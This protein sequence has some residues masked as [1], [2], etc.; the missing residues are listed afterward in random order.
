MN[1]ERKM[2]NAEKNI[3]LEDE[4]KHRPEVLDIPPLN[5][6]ITQEAILTAEFNTI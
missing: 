5:I 1:L 3:W 6:V 4:L 2:R